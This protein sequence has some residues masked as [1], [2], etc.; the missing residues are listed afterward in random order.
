[1]DQEKIKQFLEEY[2]LKKDTY[3]KFSVV[4]KDILE[5]LL[6]T[7]LFKYQIS[8]RGKS[9]Q[10]LRQKLTD[11][12]LPPLTS[13][14]EL[15]DLAGD[16]ILFYVDSD[17]EKFARHLFDEFEVIKRTDRYSEDDYNAVHLVVK[18]TKTRI[19][20]PEYAQFDGLI[21]EIQLSTILYHAWS[22]MAHD[23][24]Y[25]PPPGFREF[26]ERAYESLQKRFRSI[27][28]EH[29]KKASHDFEFISEQVQ[30][31]NE[32]KQVFDLDFLS[33]VE[34]S[35]SNNEIYQNLKLLT[36][37]LGEF[38]DKTPT[39]LNIIRLIRTVLGKSPQLKREPIRTAIG[40]LEG[41]DF[42]AVTK[43]C[44]EILNML[45]Y[46]YPEDVFEILVELSKSTGPEISKEALEVLE[47][48]SRYNLP[49]LKQAG[50][51]VQ[52]F[53]LGKI[54]T[55]KEQELK[56]NLEAILVL[57]KQL[58]RSSFEGTSWH[59]YNKVDFSSGALIVNDNLREIRSK[60]A[61]ILQK[62]YHLS[63]HLGDEIRVLHALEEAVRTPHHG[64][65]AEMESLV[66]DAANDLIEFYVTLASVPETNG[67]VFELI[68]EKMR[69]LIH[70]FG[71][72]KFTTIR[73]L[74]SLVDAN[75]EYQ[76]FRLLVGYD[77]RFAPDFDF[78]KD[79]KERE[80]KVEEFVAGITDETF[81]V[82]QKR[83]VAILK[84]Y[85]RTD[86]GQY[87]YL[88]TFLRKIAEQKA[89]LALTFLR[90]NEP[91]LNPV[92][93]D[94]LSG[95]WRSSAKGAAKQIIGRWVNEGKYLPECASIFVRVEEIDEA[96][97]DQIFT[98]AVAN[99][100][101]A[102]LNHLVDSIARHYPRYKQAPAAFM[103]VVQELTRHHDTRWINYV[104]Y[105]KESIITALSGTDYDKI[106]ENLLWLPNIDYH[107]EAILKPT[108]E[109]YP[110]KVLEFFHTR[111]GFQL[112]ERKTKTARTY[113]A[114]PFQF[115]K[116]GQSLRNHEDLVI[117]KLLEWY[118]DT[119]KEDGWFY[120]WEISHF[121]KI[122]FPAF[123]KTLERHFIMEI[124]ARGVD[125][126]SDV[127]SLLREYTG[128][129]FLWGLCKAIITK[130]AFDEKYTDIKTHL[131]AL[132]SQT[133]VVSGEYGFA[134]AYD[135]K[136]QDLKSWDH[137]GVPA[138]KEFLEEYNRYLHD[139]VVQAR[140]K[141][142][143]DIELRKRRFES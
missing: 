62:V 69:W 98:K 119:P 39:E 101:V 42:V 59:D 19:A 71:A 27:M 139:L 72:A 118:K 131:F 88:H 16:R 134:E 104:W 94:L 138:F 78:E 67:H 100:D 51:A 90:E 44:L 80:K 83:L 50:Y 55:W 21:C 13:V 35:V 106:L 105:Q 96:L 115:H 113:D 20:L 86:P 112:R 133:G 45:K 32:G 8:P 58:L 29:I 92:L 107:A 121:I 52:D 85:E 117:P 36:Q 108:A 43:V 54:E 84:H 14:T 24:I 142:D 103:K 33:H 31:I 128:K 64:S 63:K 11:D 74:E 48:L 41:Y 114:I 82:W 57:G 6:K 99:E 60:A 79:R 37:Y 124:E 47:Q 135:K 4:V 3:Q 1:M 110:L 125:S 61:G 70:Q 25:K 5:A 81:P 140:K 95:I 18:L 2:E 109:N 56:D 102:A 87:Q 89:P 93:L 49:I 34:R 73:K 40:E 23:I 68:E 46:Q 123:T 141:A 76:I 9:P 17:I 136:R 12:K 91:D 120:R 75:E 77:G 38:G 65:T 30:K 111:I 97:L 126:I 132:L 15:Q 53:I 130:V 26:D 28:E 66:I 143:E 116:L 22:E 10:S 7:H 129:S 127:M 137:E 122:V